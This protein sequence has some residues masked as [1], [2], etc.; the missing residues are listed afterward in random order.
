[1]PPWASVFIR[2][3]EQPLNYG[4]IVSLWCWLPGNRS[5][6]PTDRKIT[7]V[8]DKV[9]SATKACLSWSCLRKK[10][11]LLAPLK[12]E[13]IRCAKQH[14]CLTAKLFIWA[15]RCYL[16]STKSHKKTQ[17]A[18]E[19]VLCVFLTLSCN[20]TPPEP[21]FTVCFLCRWSVWK[22]SGVGWG[23]PVHVWYFI[24]RSPAPQDP[25]TEAGSQRYK[26]PVCL[27]LRVF[28]FHSSSVS[29]GLAENAFRWEASQINQAVSLAG[30][31]LCH[32][33]GTGHLT[34][35]SPLFGHHFNSSSQ[36]Y[37]LWC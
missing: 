7:K 37:W 13:K 5:G 9:P 11:Q 15:C 10:C 19:C 28:L 33:A 22:V 27:W 3:P 18:E 34:H 4:L 26:L 1:M 12:R 20:K 35:I 21:V 29:A 31:T 36:S 2:G 14:R 17:N 30:A 24:L 25:P 32:R 8:S 6:R 23:R 16:A